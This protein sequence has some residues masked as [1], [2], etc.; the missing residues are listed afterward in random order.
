MRIR[1]VP[2]LVARYLVAV[3]LV[4][5]IL[6]LVGLVSEYGFGTDLIVFDLDSEGNLPTWVAVLLLAFS[7]LL[8]GLISLLKVRS[9]GP[10][11]LHWWGLAALFTAFSF[12]EVAGFHERLIGPIRAW[13]SLPGIFHFAW[14]LAGLVFTL[15]VGV[16]YLPFLRHLR[17]SIR[18]LFVASGA[19]YVG[20]ALGIEMLQGYT[21]VQFTR[22]SLWF[23][24]AA[25]AEEG[26]E[27]FG[28]TLFIYT[29]LR[30]L[31]DEPGVT[32]LEIEKRS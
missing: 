7:A 4:L 9:E 21:E 28:V 23:E 24:F 18:N 6:N 11:Q 31:Q 30:Y 3:V 2:G 26:L 17:A 8:L 29:L 22:Q 5:L 32:V 12:E 19:L 13:L 15:V 27:L 1:V 14:V 16:I 25:F 10:F 20:G